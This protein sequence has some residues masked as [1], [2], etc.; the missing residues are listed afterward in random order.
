MALAIV[1]A[2]NPDTPANVPAGRAELPDMESATKPRLL[3]LGRAASLCLR[4]QGSIV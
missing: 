3:E 1:R 4:S 2:T